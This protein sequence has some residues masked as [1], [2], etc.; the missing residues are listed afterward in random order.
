MTDP[1][2]ASLGVEDLLIPQG[3][4]WSVAWVYEESTDGGATRQAVNLSTGWVAR[5]EIR[6]EPRDPTVLARF[7][8]SDQAAD[9]RILL[10]ADGTVT[11]SLPADASTGWTWEYG[12]YDVELKHPASGRVV[13]LMSGVARLSPEVTT[14]E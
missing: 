10:A 2:A 12:K 9:G 1:L 14:G 6:K 7:H 8:S 5:C 3:A 4:T 11:L 13:R